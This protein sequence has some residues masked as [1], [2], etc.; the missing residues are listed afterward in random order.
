MLFSFWKQT[1]NYTLLWFYHFPSL[2]LSIHPPCQ[3]SPTRSPLPIAPPTFPSTEPP[4]PPVLERQLGEEGAF[5]W[6][7]ALSFWATSHSSQAWCQ[8]AACSAERTNSD[9]NR[10]MMWE[11]LGHFLSVW[12]WPGHLTSMD[13][14]PSFCKRRIGYHPAR[15][16]H[17]QM[18][19]SLTK[20][21]TR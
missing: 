5:A 13:L 11:G 3:G 12:P 19:L 6:S 16:Y 7:P 4:S 1:P 18:M 8:E 14:S 20:A 10:L 15:W 9:G 2:F 21:C 17:D